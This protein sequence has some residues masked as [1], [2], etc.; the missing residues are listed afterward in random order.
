MLIEPT[1][2]VRRKQAGEAP[3]DGRVNGVMGESGSVVLFA[4][5]LPMSEFS[6]VKLP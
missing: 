2:R 6:T 5:F 4:W 3:V 1:G